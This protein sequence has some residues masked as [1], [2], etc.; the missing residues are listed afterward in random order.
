M[1]EYVCWNEEYEEYDF[2]NW[3]LEQI[4]ISTGERTRPK[5][6]R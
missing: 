2:D 3:Y 5:L 6:K 4:D 1:Y